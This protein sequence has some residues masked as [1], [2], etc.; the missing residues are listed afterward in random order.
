MDMEITDQVPAKVNLSPPKFERC[1]S[2]TG[3]QPGRSPQRDQKARTLR[4]GV[5]TPKRCLSHSSIPRTNSWA[6]TSILV[7]IWP[8][9]WV[10]R[11]SSFQRKRGKVR[12]YLDGGV[13]DIVMSAFPMRV[14]DLGSMN[15]SRPD[16]DMKAAFI[17]KDYRKKEFQTRADIAAL[18][19]LRIAV[20]PANSAED[21]RLLRDYLP[22]AKLVELE[23][24]RD[25]FSKAD[26]A[27]ALLTTDK[28]GKAWALL[29]PEF[30]V[31]VPK[32]HLFVYDV[33][34]PIP[35]AKGDHIFLEYLNHWL[36]LHQTTGEMAQQFDYWIL[37]KTPYRK[38]PRWL[39][40]PKRAALG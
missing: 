21:R 38:K 12:D 30:G 24:I 1:P 31:A 9:T 32:P 35:I 5:T 20:T 14:D 16:M 19:G 6:M 4:V 37:G 2:Q 36:T 40:C 22:N 27:D 17:V 18:K 39:H 13:C 10:S 33:T 11:S 7:T 29:C 8:G 28:I 34:Y 15:F 23:S 25:F 3:R 26:V